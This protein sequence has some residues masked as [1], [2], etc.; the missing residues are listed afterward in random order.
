MKLNASSRAVQRITRVY[1]TL[2][3]LYP[4]GFRA[5]YEQEMKALFEERCQEAYEFSGN[6]GIGR[7]LLKIVLREVVSLY[8]EYLDMVLD[9]F[10]DD[11]DARQLLRLGMLFLAG[12][13]IALF[14][15]AASSTGVFIPGAILV[16]MNALLV[17]RSFL[18]SER[19]EYVAGMAAMSNIILI[20]S[21][22]AVQ[23][24]VESLAVVAYAIQVSLIGLHGRLLWHLRG[25]D[26]LHEQL[27]I[28][29]GE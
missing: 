10:E 13:W 25:E 17:A 5:E 20:A 18:H 26:F 2:L 24:S 16:L 3:V 12:T 28:E 21:L 9:P 4:A 29:K 27:E 19:I 23:A 11:R 6:I 14:F 1:H 15:L 7:W 8:K 22:M